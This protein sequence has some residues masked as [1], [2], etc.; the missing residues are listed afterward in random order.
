MTTISKE[1]KSI[2]AS[3]IEE[4]VKEAD[5]VL[6]LESFLKM[7]E[8]REKAIAENRRF[9]FDAALQKARNET[10]RQKSKKKADEELNALLKSI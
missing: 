6:T 2:L 7:T 3:T 4:S 9:N 8:E 1:T 5:N 10:L